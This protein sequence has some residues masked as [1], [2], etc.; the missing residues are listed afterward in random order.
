[1]NIL[2]DLLRFRKLIAPYI[3]EL[4]FWAGVAGTLYGSYW[5]FMH[6]HWAWWVALVF[7]TLLT[8]LIFEFALLA[9]RS[10]DRLVDIRNALTADAHADKTSSRP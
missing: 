10:Y 4:L 5:L 1:M 6:D 2:F 9:F 8:R 7:G 3:L